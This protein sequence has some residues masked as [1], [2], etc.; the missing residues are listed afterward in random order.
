MLSKIIFIIAFIFCCTG[1]KGQGKDVYAQADPIK[2]YRFDKA[3]YRLITSGNDVGI[4]GELLCDYPE[5]M[6]VT[7]KGLLNMPTTE[8]PGFFDRLA[9][10]YSEPTLRKLYREAIEQYDSI[11]DIEQTLG[12]AFAYLK[13]N[14]PAMPVPRIYMHVSGL[15]QNVWAA[16]HLLSLSIDKYMGTDYPLYQNFFY[17]FQREKMQRA[18]VVPDYLTGWL[19]SEYPFAGKENVLLERMV[20]EGKI[21]YLVQQALPDIPPHVLMGFTEKA[22][23]WCKMNE[24]EIWKTLVERKHLYTPDLITTNK[25]IEDTPAAFL[26][27]EAPGNVG[28]W[29]GLQIVRRYMEETG[30]TPERLIQETN[31]QDI[32]RQ[33]KYK[34]F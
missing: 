1:C 14:L 8:T 31:A 3:L 28:V 16:H 9:K 13:T 24:A 7:G 11:A 30:A 29:M 33:S 23:N 2:I 5:M 19:L 26:S 27:D 34:P 15:S 18:R 21:K 25:Y 32:L 4:Q 12:Q 20:Y 6:E 17:D 10:F 22:Y